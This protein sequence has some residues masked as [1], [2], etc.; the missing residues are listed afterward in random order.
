[1]PVSR[2]G[3]CGRSL[4]HAAAP[5]GGGNPIF[6]RASGDWLDWNTHHTANGEDAP[7][8]AFAHPLLRYKTQGATWFSLIGA[9]EQ[10]PRQLFCDR[11]RPALAEWLGRPTSGQFHCFAN[12][13]RLM[14]FNNSQSIQLR[15]WQ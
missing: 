1:M 5:D 4:V 7:S 10:D 9:I 12:D 3:P 11:R 6:F 8:L 2:P 15:V 14:C 13:V